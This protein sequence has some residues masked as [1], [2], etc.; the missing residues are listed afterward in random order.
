MIGGRWSVDGVFVVGC[1]MLV[2]VGWLHVFV[3]GW[4]LLLGV[5]SLLIVC[6]WL[7][8]VCVVLCLAFYF[9]FFFVCVFGF[10]FVRLSVDD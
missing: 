7:C 4:C 6:G 10:L 3:R 5:C 2:I 8:A 9:L 1:W